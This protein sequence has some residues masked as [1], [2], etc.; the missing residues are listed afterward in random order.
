MFRSILDRF[1]ALAGLLVA[2]PVL[3]AAAICVVVQDGKPI[4]FRQAR[5]G[6]NGHPFEL[7]KFR[8][9]YIGR[10]GLS[11][12]AGSDARVTPVGR[13][14]RRYKL[15][16]LPQLWNVARGDMSLIGP[17]P[18]VPE[19]VDLNDQTWQQVL[20]VLPGICDLASL[21]Y[22]NE[23][24][25]LARVSETERFY[26]EVLLPAKLALSLHYLRTRSITSDLRL[27]LLTLRFSFIPSGFDPKAIKQRFCFQ[28]D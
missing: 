26:R 22:R 24:T 2:S 12:T 23:E 4:L 14:L 19:F 28:E 13:F 8:S 20:E 18:E 15:D 6:R 9:M 5:I 3:A 27:L 16:E 10:T 11:V 21:V 7:L 25:L 1:T 17:R